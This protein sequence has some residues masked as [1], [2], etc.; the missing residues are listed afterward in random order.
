MTE[1]EY[2]Q[3]QKKI[4]E[5][6]TLLLKEDKYSEE[7]IRQLHED[8]QEATSW[9]KKH[10]EAQGI[11]FP[12]ADFSN[13]DI[14]AVVSRYL[15]LKEDGIYY[16]GR[17]PFHDDK[18][19]NGTLRVMPIPGGDGFFYCDECGIGG[20]TPKFLS[21]MEKINYVEACKRLGIIVDG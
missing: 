8:M 14:C 13:V 21:L 15:P 20:N 2:S 5:S 7:Q 11:S 4:G 18:S 1:E 17:C 16:R 3:L 19:D 9:K 12:E 6:L 10:L